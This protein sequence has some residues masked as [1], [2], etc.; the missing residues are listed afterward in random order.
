MP[1]RT[2]K[3]FEGKAKVKLSALIAS[4]TI[5]SLLLDAGKAVT[6]KQFHRA[7]GVYRSDRKVF[8]R[9]GEFQEHVI[10]PCVCYTGANKYIEI[11]RKFHR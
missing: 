6:F 10:A 5:L 1:R 7:H 8:E 4:C 3:G 11:V 2:G 9:A